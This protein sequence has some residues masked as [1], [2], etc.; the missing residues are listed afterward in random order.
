MAPSRTGHRGAYATRATRR[1]TASRRGARH[2][3]PKAW[4]SAR[5]VCGILGTLCGVIGCFGLRDRTGRHRVGRRGAPAHSRIGWHDQGRRPRVG[6][7]WCSAS[8]APSHP[9]AGSSRSPPIPELRD[10][11]ERPDQHHDHSRLSERRYSTRRRPLGAIDASA[12]GRS[13]TNSVRWAGNTC[14]LTSTGS[15]VDRRGDPL[16]AQHR[17]ARRAPRAARRRA[18]D[19]AAAPIVCTAPPSWTP[20]QLVERRALDVGPRQLGA[21]AARGTTR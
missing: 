10:R 5:S 12:W 20:M 6:R 4:P 2:R 11:L 8:S 3:R 18:L 9:L 7:V 17:R 1:A 19:A 16:A 13:T 21:V 14:S 15:P